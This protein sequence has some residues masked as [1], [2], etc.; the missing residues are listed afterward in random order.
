MLSLSCLSLAFASGKKSKP[1]AK[2]LHDLVLPTCS[3]LYYSPCSSHFS[4]QLQLPSLCSLMILWVFLFKSEVTFCSFCLKC[5]S[6]DFSNGWSFNFHVYLDTVPSLCTQP[7]SIPFSNKNLLRFFLIL[8]WSIIILFIYLF[9]CLLS[10]S[11]QCEFDEDRD[12]IGLTH[13]CMTGV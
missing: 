13:Y 9:S 10:S 1:L 2:F 4:L 12:L 5:F 3:T 11:L 7:L 6:L 8:L